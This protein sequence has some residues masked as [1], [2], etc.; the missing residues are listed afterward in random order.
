MSPSPECVVEA[1]QPAPGPPLLPGEKPHPW[2]RLVARLI[3]VAMARMLLIAIMLGIGLNV[4]DPSW[5]LLITPAGCIWALV[6]SVLL[7]HGKSTPGKW[8]LRTRVESIGGGPLTFARAFDRSVTAFM[9]GMGCCTNP[10]V[11]VC[12]GLSYQGLLDSGTTHWDRGKF[13]LRHDP[14]SPGRFMLMILT[15]IGLLTLNTF[16]RITLLV[17]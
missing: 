17:D 12:L 13:V 4:R 3:D 1:T 9:W 15:I 11:V 8:L 14:L 2:R 6:E 5:I 10:F 7:C 16:L